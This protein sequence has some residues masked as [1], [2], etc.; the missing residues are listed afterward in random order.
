MLRIIMLVSVVVGVFLVVT[1]LTA[2]PNVPAIPDRELIGGELG[3][4]FVFT[5]AAMIIVTPP[6]DRTAYATPLQRIASA[7]L[8]LLALAIFIAIA[9]WFLHYFGPPSV[10]K[11]FTF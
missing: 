10:Q 3:L 2:I 11:Q 8:I 9:V 5:V 6:D 1:R 7:L 4:A